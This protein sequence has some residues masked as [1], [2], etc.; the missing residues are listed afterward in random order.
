MQSTE[1][2]ALAIGLLIKLRCRRVR[3]Q[4]AGTAT[5]GHLAIPRSRMG[6]STNAHLRPCSDGLDDAVQV[7]D[8]LHVLVQHAG[9][10]P[11]QLLASRQA[12]P[13]NPR[14]QWLAWLVHMSVLF[15]HAH[16]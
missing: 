14:W 6:P 9:R 10:L 11:R 12:R 3:Q 2:V 5:A 1:V 8:A 15:L 7:V 13:A 16:A 4:H